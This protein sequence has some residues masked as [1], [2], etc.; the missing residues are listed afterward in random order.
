MTKK[1]T[2]SAVVVTYNAQRFIRGCLES[3]KGWVDEIILVDMFSSDKTVEITRHYTERIIQSEEKSHE[4][5]TNIGIDAAK[6]E[7]ILKVLA[8]ER[9]TPELRDEIIGTINDRKRKY[10]GY[11]VPR[12]SYCICEFIE[13]RPG[14]IYLFKKG[15]GK[16]N[17]LRIHGQI[18]LKGKVGYLKNFNIHWTSLN[19]EY[20][21]DKLNQATSIEAKIA[22]SGHPD[23]FW[24]KRP[25]YN[26][27]P[28]NLFYRM[29][30]GFYMLYIRAKFYRY[31]MHGFIESIAT[32][33]YFFVEMAKLWELQYKKEHNIK[34]ELL[35]PD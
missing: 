17:P 25:V 2:I 28:F 33:F 7:W 10:L 5:R 35:P 11:H 21:I 9:I 30:A 20:G 16:F 15:A 8:T 19:F 4:A 29:A 24:W 23:A 13:E 12:K 3:L 32:S 26:V 1:A 6:S 27:T 22:F 31:G 18:E 34:D 14:P